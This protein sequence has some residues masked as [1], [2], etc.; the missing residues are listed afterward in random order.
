MTADNLSAI[1]AGLLAL[2][3]AYVPGLS[4]WY[5]ALESKHKALVMAGALLVVAVGV[6]GL[7]CAGLAGDFGLTVTC[8]RP[9]IVGL[10]NAFIAALVANQATYV[11]AVRPW[12]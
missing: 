3:F 5:G 9:G 6:V 8:D 1:V 12:K 2:L 10:V 7:A 4:D 11:I